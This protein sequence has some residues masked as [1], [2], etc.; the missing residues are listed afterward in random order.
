[1]SENNEA[2]KETENQPAEEA[3]ETMSVMRAGQ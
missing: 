1:M 3:A 2:V